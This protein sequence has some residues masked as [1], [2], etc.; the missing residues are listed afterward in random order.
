MSRSRGPGKQPAAAPVAPSGT[1]SALLARIDDVVKLL[2]LACRRSAA[3]PT[4][5]QTRKPRTG[6]GSLSC[7]TGWTLIWRGSMGAQSEDQV[8]AWVR[9]HQ[10]YSELL[11]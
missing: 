1:D 4:G 7:A 3:I 11:H 2:L 5:W 10:P 8:G 6:S 9:A